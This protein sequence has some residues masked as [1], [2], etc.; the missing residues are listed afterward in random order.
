MPF[1]ETRYEHVVLDDKGVPCIEGT[2]MK[3]IELIMSQRA[4]G[5]SAEELQ[6]QH[7]PLTLGQIYS[8]L[9]YYWDHQAELDAEIARR[10][11]WADQMRETTP[12][13]PLVQRLRTQE[14]R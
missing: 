6:V 10:V 3:I 13:I 9:A 14:R 4:N 2:A 12:P 8:V 5:W 1:V 11:A 7:P